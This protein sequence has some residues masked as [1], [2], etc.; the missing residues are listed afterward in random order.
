MISI[1]KL[2]TF[3]ASHHLPR[4]EG[5]CRKLHGHSYKLK[6]E[7]SGDFDPLTGMVIDF[8]D[9]TEAVNTVIVDVLDHTHLND[10]YFNPTAE[11]VIQQM[12]EDLMD[13]FA[14]ANSRVKLEKLTLW[15][16]EKCCA[17]W[18]NI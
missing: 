10:R 9:L 11:V 3:E 7:V 6:V 5:H 17:I 2:F 18:R 15:E 4:H 16:T 1:E 8:Q 14:A 12:A 13:H